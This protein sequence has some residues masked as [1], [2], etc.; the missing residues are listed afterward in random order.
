MFNVN[1]IKSPKSMDLD[2]PLDLENY[3]GHVIDY[4]SIFSKHLIS[5]IRLDYL[6]LSLIN[7]D[8]K[9]LDYLIDN[10]M[11]ILPN[12]KIMD[13][14]EMYYCYFHQKRNLSIDQDIQDS[15]D[16]DKEEFTR[17][18][19]KI[20]QNENK[21]F[22]TVYYSRIKHNVIIK[23]K[24]FKEPFK[25]ISI[26]VVGDFAHKVLESLFNG[27]ID[28]KKY[29]LKISRLD[30]KVYL[31]SFQLENYD[32]ECD[33]IEEFYSHQRRWFNELQ[34]G[35]EIV[36]KNDPN[37]DFTCVLFHRRKSVWYF[38][39]YLDKKQNKKTC[40]LELK[41]GSLQ[42][43]KKAI[44]NRDIGHFNELCVKNF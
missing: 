12:C 39:I 14:D 3:I 28:L 33:K 13:F 30:L 27:T 18:I 1:K 4:P 8:E 9:S 11:Q 25:P 16:L 5:S 19:K 26:Y 38:R 23:N 20:L 43:F 2:R 29:N 24:T 22:S 7:E 17:D 21:Q 36:L 42:G 37:E 34:K 10:F 44:E 41:G 35:Y 40:E 31:T 6:T 32:K 15:I